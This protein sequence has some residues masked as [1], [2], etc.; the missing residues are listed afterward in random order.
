MQLQ[1]IHMK[2]KKI[3]K[4]S[5]FFII[6]STLIL[7][8]GCEKKEENLVIDIDGNEYHTV[9]IGN[10]VWMVENLRTTRYSNGDTILEVMN[11]NQWTKMTSGA[12]CYYNDYD[13]IINENHDIY[14][15]IATY[16]YLYNWYAVTDS[17]KIAPEGWHVATADDWNTLINYVGGKDVAAGKLK[18]AGTKHWRTQDDNASNELGFTALPGGGCTRWGSFEDITTHGNWWTAS[19]SDENLAFAY[20]IY[21]FM[22]GWEW[23]RSLKSGI[24]GPQAYFKVSGLSVR[25]VKD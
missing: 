7:M 8:F 9:T 24:L 21:C 23:N 25:C 13:Y 5:F 11:A 1:I 2:A 3:G 16:G 22:D 12:C 20:S 19:E 18:E 4:A 6:V 17:R 14:Q 10:Q 15:T